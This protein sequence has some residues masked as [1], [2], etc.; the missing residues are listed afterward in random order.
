M[1][2]FRIICCKTNAVFSHWL[3]NFPK[4]MIAFSQFQL[5][6]LGHSE[7][8][9]TCCLVCFQGIVPFIFVGTVESITNAGIL[10]DYHLAHLKVSASQL[11]QNT[12]VNFSW[13]KDHRE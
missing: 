10:L 3:T 7:C 11:P 13:M 2:V 5:V 6:F 9:H 4:V 1:E 8:I 12:I